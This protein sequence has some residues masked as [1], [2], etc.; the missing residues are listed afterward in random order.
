MKFDAPLKLRKLFVVLASAVVLVLLA[1]SAFVAHTLYQSQQRYY[2]EAENTSRNLAVSLENAL[3]SHFQEVELAMQRA[4]AEFRLMHAERRFTPQQFSAY[5]RSLKERM[6]QAQAVRGTDANG[7]VI[8]GEDIDMAKPVNL[9]IR[10]FYQRATTERALVFGVPIKS[11]ITGDMVFPLMYAM[12]YP[13]GRFGGTAYVNMNISRINEVISSLELGKHGVVTM[14]DAQRRLLYRFPEVAG[15]IDGEA[16]MIGLEPA[17]LLAAGGKRG[18]FTGTS[19]L[20]G[21]RRRFS[22]ERIGTYPVYIV[23]GLAESDFLAA[24]DSEV[25]NAA[26]FLAV[27]YLLAATLL[28]G[29]YMSLQRQTHAARELLVKEADLQCSL[30]ALTQS[31]ARFR[32]LTEG[33]PQMV[34]TLSP[35]FRFDFI[36]HHWRDYTGLGEA[37]LADEGAF[38]VIVHPDD[39]AAMRAAWQDA[40]ADGGQFRCD[41]RIRRHDGVWR[42]FDNHGLSQL[43]AHGALVCWVGSSTDITAQ[44]EAHDALLLAKDQALLAGRAKSEFLANMSHEIRSP[45]NAVFGMLQLLQRTSLSTLQRDYAG[46]AETSAKALLGILN[47]ILDFSKVEE[48]KLALD[49]HPFSVDKLLR[50]LAVILSANASGKNIEVLFNISPDIPSWLVGDQL[51][52]QQVLLNLAGNAIKFTERGEVVLTVLPV[53]AGADWIDLSFIVRDSGIGISAANLEHIFEGFSQAEASTA[54]RFGG[55]GLG[56]TISQR[57]VQ[58]MG[59]TLAVASMPGQGSVFDFTIRLQRTAHVAERSSVSRLQQL[60]CLI[61]DDNASGRDVLTAIVRSFGW[62]AEVAES[63]FEALGKVASAAAERP[64]DV[65]FMDWRMPGLDGWETSKQIRLQAREGKAPLIVMVTAHDRQLVTEFESQLAPVLDAMLSKPVTASLL[66]EAV[67]ELTMGVRKLA[68]ALPARDGG[69][70]QGLRLLVVDDNAMNQQVASELLRA[71]GAVIDVADSGGEAV[72]AVCQDGVRYDLVLMDIQMPD[73]DGY[74]T[75]AAI[76][77]RLGK[78]APPIVAMTA[79][80]MPAD[81]DAAHAAGMADHVGKP[82]DLEQLVA[83]ILRHAQGAAA[84]NAARAITRLGGNADVYRMALRSFDGE[85]KKLLP[86]LELARSEVRA[87]LA[88]PALHVLKGLAG[89]IGAEALALVAAEAEALSLQG[90]LDA[91]GWAMVERVMHEA[92]AAR[93]EAAR[94]VA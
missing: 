17:A 70:L 12:I 29:V 4:R 7:T 82:F 42:L 3:Y 39:Q 40:R 73:M 84:L 83:V 61:V 77:A 15:A 71:D 38:P 48:G 53:D 78:G 28:T 65:V 66:F 57:L 56:L 8:Y 35:A 64:Y 18:T 2:A 55:T 88:A 54:R 36:S 80:A 44:R 30:A 62:S 86:Q 69:R 11:R 32:S 94:M 43:D 25:R 92:G 51:R 1:V 49:P 74:A 31:E 58:L 45:M 13:D 24:W 21:Q 10:E 33:L 52:L 90:P 16:R 72:H 9:Q 34:W 60:H 59:G 85:L 89:T 68:P 23:V 63:G 27:L 37:A 91:S 93:L 50:E 47:D 67:G 76:L 81:R 20:D 46:K 79:N 19:A 41:C 6:P 22:I 14:L 5:L 75:T 26:A 87:D